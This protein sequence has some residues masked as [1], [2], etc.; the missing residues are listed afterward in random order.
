MVIYPGEVLKMERIV[1][2]KSMD[3]GGWVMDGIVNIRLDGG[4]LSRQ[5]SQR[6]RRAKGI[7]RFTTTIKISKQYGRNNT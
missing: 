1:K 5:L 7:L 2:G 6:K 3:T 4:R